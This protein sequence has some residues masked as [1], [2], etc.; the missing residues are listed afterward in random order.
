V[1]HSGQFSSDR[2]IMEYARG[3]WRAAAC[4]VE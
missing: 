3:I 2:T 4:P 1:A